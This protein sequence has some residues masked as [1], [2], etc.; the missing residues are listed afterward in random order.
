MIA[1]HIAI[2]AALATAFGIDV[3]AHRYGRVLLQA[4]AAKARVPL[5]AFDHWTHRARFT[6]RLCHVD[7]GFAMQA[8]ATGVSAATNEKGFHCGAC[9]NGRTAFEGKPIFASCSAAG[10]ARTEAPCRR[11]HSGES[12]AKSAADHAALKLPRA[13]FGEID[14][15]KAEDQGLVHPLDAL[16]GVSTPRPPLRMDRDVDIATHGAWMTD[17]K[18]SHKKHAVW[19]GCEVCHPEIFPKTQA[20]AAKFTMFQIAAGEAC[21]ACHGKVAFALAYCDKCHVK[22]VRFP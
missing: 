3:P 4:R 17:V 14:W 19:N 15:Q 18:F 9:H 10:D 6:C 8:G 12:Q 20:G 22:P 5:V 21:G 7:V 2:A 1:R 11:C 13:A 16:E